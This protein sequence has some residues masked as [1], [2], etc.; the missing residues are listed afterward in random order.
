MG[1]FKLNVLLCKQAVS[2]CPCCYTINSN[3]GPANVIPQAPNGFGLA[4][5][6]FLCANG[7]ESDPDGQIQ[8]VQPWQSSGG[9]QVCFLAL[10]CLPLRK[11][12]EYS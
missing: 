7:Y 9:Q 10:L 1:F 12:Q 11:K 6:D 4:L 5:E 8:D 2:G 3:Q